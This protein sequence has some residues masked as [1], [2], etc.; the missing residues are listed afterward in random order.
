MTWPSLC[1][2]KNWRFF[3][4]YTMASYKFGWCLEP[5]GREIM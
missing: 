5:W 1:H 4:L 2:R 3:C